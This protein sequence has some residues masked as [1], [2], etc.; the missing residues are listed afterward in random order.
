MVGGG[1]GAGSKGSKGRL[2]TLSLAWT[3]AWTWTWEHGH[4]WARRLLSWG[5]GRHPYQ[6]PSVF[7]KVQ[8]GGGQQGR[9]VG[10]ALLPPRSA[11]TSCR[12]VCR[13]TTGVGDAVASSIK[14]GRTSQSRGH[15]AAGGEGRGRGRNANTVPTYLPYLPYV[16]LVDDMACPVLF[17]PSVAG[18][19]RSDAQRNAKKGV[20]GGHVE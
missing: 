12:V 18:P 7:E 11:R 17:C 19:V 3:R 1:K 20:A 8:A 4:L 2:E 13:W 14:H 6:V 15:G 9:T 10:S 16:C 5:P